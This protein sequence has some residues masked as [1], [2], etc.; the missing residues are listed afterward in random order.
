MVITLYTTA[1]RSIYNDSTIGIIFSAI[2]AINILEL[3]KNKA[4]ILSLPILIL[5][6]LFREVGLVLAVFAAI[7]LIANQIRLQGLSSISLSKW[8]ILFVMLASPIVASNLWMNYF[9]STHDFFG[10][11]EH[12]LNNL[13]VLAQSF[14][15]QHKLLLISFLKCFSQFLFIYL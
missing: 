8:I 6:P 11:T 2:F 3:N 13:V 9:R 7:I 14:D 5:L 1:I 4:L 12:N 10:R 15:T